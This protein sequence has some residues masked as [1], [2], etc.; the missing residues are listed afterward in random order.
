VISD[1]VMPGMDGIDLAHEIGRRHPGLPVV[2][3]SGYSQLLAE[4]GISG[5]RLIYKPY[6]IEEFSLVLRKAAVR[7]RRG[8]GP[9]VA[10]AQRPSPDGD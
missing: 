6:S 10:R 8:E 2:L 5:S 7:H 3:A 1:V 9:T 4:K